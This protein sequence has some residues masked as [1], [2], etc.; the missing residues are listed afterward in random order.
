MAGW[1]NTLFPCINNGLTTASRVDSIPK[2]CTSDTSQVLR[3]SVYSSFHHA[4]HLVRLILAEIILKKG[5][6]A[7]SR[8]KQWILGCMK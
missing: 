7:I 5:C 6:R 2:R 4:Y 1:F 3:G 8:I